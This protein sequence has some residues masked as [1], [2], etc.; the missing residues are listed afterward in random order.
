MFAKHRHACVAALAAAAFAVPAAAATITEVDGPAPGRVVALD[1]AAFVGSGTCGYGG[2]VVGTGPGRGCS[3]VI[4]NDPTAPDAFGRA[5]PFGGS[6]IDSQDLS[7]VVWS[8]DPGY[9]FTALTFALFDAYDQLPSRRW[10]LGESFFRLSVDDATWSIPSREENGTLHWL[11]VAFDAPVAV[12]DI[13]FSTR[14]NDGWGVSLSG[15]TTVPPPPPP[16][17]P[18]TVPLPATA[19]LIAAALAGLAALGL[20]RRA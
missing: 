3:V 15:A 6:W 12:A 13:R 18:A 1:P 4:K 16:P 8:F 2:S 20:R 19:P 14:L 17:P 7:E 11:T 5:D 10:P 9:A